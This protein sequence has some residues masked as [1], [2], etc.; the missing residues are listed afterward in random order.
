MK[1]KLQIEAKRRSPR[2]RKKDPP[3][4][5]ILICGSTKW[6]KVA[7]IRKALR[8]FY[9]KN[10]DCVIIGTASGAEKLALMLAKYDRFN[11]VLVPP[12]VERDGKDANYYRNAWVWN[13][14]KPTQVLAFH[15]DIE[16]SKSTAQY[17]KLAK[18]KNV[19]YKLF[20][21]HSD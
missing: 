14:F 3:P 16:N 8:K 13:L 1:D 10:V 12:N 5:R 21:G 11:I 7:I 17:L 9:Y 2:R 6:N 4:E 15:Q 20:D 18:A 19:P